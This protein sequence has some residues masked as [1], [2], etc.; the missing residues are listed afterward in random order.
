[1]IYTVY[2]TVG[3]AGTLGSKPRHLTSDAW[4][5]FEMQVLGVAGILLGYEYSYQLQ[6]SRRGQREGE[7][8]NLVC[9]LRLIC[10]LA[11]RNAP[12]AALFEV[13]SIT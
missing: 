10:S 7:R 1:M 11:Q 13:T 12:C 9:R 6:V 5:D 4:P 2:Q 8:E 3:H